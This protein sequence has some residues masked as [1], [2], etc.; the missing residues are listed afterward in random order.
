VQHLESV[1]IEGP[2]E[3][4]PDVLE[5]DAR[6][7]RPHQ[8]IT[9]GELDLPRYCEPVDLAPDTPVVSVLAWSIPAGTKE[10]TSTA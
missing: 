9:V 3:M 8:S 7:L 5:I 4:L 1:R 6:R 2:V 10:G